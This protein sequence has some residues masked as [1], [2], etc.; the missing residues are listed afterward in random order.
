METIVESIF[1]NED[2]IEEEIIIENV[3]EIE[4]KINVK[5]NLEKQLETEFNKPE[6]LAYTLE[7]R[8]SSIPCILLC[9]FPFTIIL[10]PYIYYLYN[11]NI[12]HK[13]EEKQKQLDKLNE[14]FKLRQTKEYQI[15]YIQN[16]IKKYKSMIDVMNRQIPNAVYKIELLEEKL[17]HLKENQ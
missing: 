16:E 10:S 12:K 11:Q 13:K 14:N 5:K 15:E 4:Y 2:F 1:E 7:K 9:C 17:N 8:I 3:S 6:Y